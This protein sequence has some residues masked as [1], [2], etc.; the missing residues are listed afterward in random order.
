MYLTSRHFGIRSFAS[1]MGALLTAGAL[2]GAV[3]PFIS[4]WLHDRF[5][6][7]DQMLVLLMALMAAGALAIATLGRPKR[8]WSVVH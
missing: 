6:G 7:Y 3:A 8:D 2:G 1:L 4:G 5:A